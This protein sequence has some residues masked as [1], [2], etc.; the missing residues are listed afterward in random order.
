M[1]V[2]SSPAPPQESSQGFALP[3]V[4]S[5]SKLCNGLMS[6]AISFRCEFPGTGLLLRLFSGSRYVTGSV[7]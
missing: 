3:F 2:I 4:C 5:G 7:R 1:N 6:V